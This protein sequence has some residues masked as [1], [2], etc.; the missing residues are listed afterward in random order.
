MADMTDPTLQRDSDR[1]L[2]SRFIAT[3]DPSAFEALV[4]LTLVD[5]NIQKTLTVT[6]A[7]NTETVTATTEEGFGFFYHQHRWQCID[8][9]CCCTCAAGRR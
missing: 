2:L 3:S 5:N 4:K 1:A 7:G 6:R 8:C 9:G